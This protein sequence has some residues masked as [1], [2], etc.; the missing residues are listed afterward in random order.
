[1]GTV[2]E[3]GVVSAFFLGA[4]TASRPRPVSCDV[5]DSGSTSS[6]SVYLRRNSRIT[7]PCP[8]GSFSSCLACTSTVLPMVLTLISSGTKPRTS[9]LS[10]KLSG[11]RDTSEAGHFELDAS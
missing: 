10:A 5:T 9:S 6:G 4:S 8:S 2:S 3:S 1:M 11:V 7:K